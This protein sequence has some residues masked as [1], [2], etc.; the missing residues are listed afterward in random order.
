MVA[1][2]TY[3]LEEISDALMAADVPAGPEALERLT[4]YTGYLLQEAIP[5][6][7]VGPQEADRLLTRHI[8]ESAVLSH[9]VEPEDRIVDVGSGAGLPGLVLACLGWH[10]DLI[11]VIEKR[12]AFLD[13]VIERLGLDARVHNTR[14]EEAGRSELRES[15]DVVLARALAAPG[16]AL[17]LCLP[18]VRV[19]GRVLIPATEDPN[20]ESALVRVAGQLGAVAP[21]WEVM[22][23]P[24]VD[25]PRY[26]MMVDKV[27]PTADAFPR[28]PGVPKRRPLG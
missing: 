28:R 6:G 1:R 18:L 20:R 26:V 3:A 8:V 15:A 7:F 11:E 27:R 4:A 2:E 12:A 19:G 9:F 16:V 21:V 17:E 14:A 13:S 10:V 23:V 25:P 24:G 5:F 22:A